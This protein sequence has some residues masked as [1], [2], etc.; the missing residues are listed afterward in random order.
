MQL[1][2]PTGCVWPASSEVCQSYTVELGKGAHA[3]AVKALNPT[4]LKL[5]IA[6]PSV[7][8]GAAVPI[9][10]AACPKYYAHFGH[11]NDHVAFGNTVH[12]G[13]SRCL[14]CSGVIADQRSNDTI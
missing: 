8:S 1:N 11:T 10:L 13:G 14:K 9:G 12:A 3:I 6:R 7:R 5:N 4:V 2:K